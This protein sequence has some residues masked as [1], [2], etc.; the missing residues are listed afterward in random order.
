MAYAIDEWPAAELEL[1]R[2]RAALAGAGMH[3]EPDPEDPKTLLV[4]LPPTT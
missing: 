1:L 2:C 4:R 3:A